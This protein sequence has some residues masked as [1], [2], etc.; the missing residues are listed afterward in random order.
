MPDAPLPFDGAI[1]RFLE[2]EAPDA[3]RTAIAEGG[4]RDI[5]STDFPYDR[6]MK[7]PDYEERIGALQLELV[8]FHAWVRESGARIVV[9][10]EGRDTA[11][12]SS[13]IARVTENLNPRTARI[14]AL[15]KP[16]ERERS[17]WYFQRYVEHL[18]AAGEM[19]LMD[20]SWYNRAVI[21]PVFGFCT[22]DQRDAF[23]AQLP[24]VERTLVTE[25]IGLIKLWFN[26]SR[27]EQLR[28]MLAREQHPLKQW[29]LS[30][31]D[32]EGLGKWDDY[33]RAIAGLFQRS[34]FDHAPWTVIRGD[35][36]YRAR[37]AAIQRILGAFDYDRKDAEAVGTPDPAIIGGPE[38]WPEG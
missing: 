37:I 9:I 36:K 11:G 1:S 3:I 6:W 23:F 19:V 2:T 14:M 10:F 22:E 4:K 38:L 24:D 15:G 26:V 34:H 27:A 31:I 32:I 8:K 7:K 30:S 12:K 5:I 28:R 18:P 25:G 13:A 20:R 33:T 16:D 35:D 21:E 29:K 17:Q